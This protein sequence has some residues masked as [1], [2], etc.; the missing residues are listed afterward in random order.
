MQPRKGVIMEYN[1]P[2]LSLAPALSTIQGTMT[3]MG[4]RT[5]FAVYGTQN[6]FRPTTAAYEADE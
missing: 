5:D 3:K 6:D 1:R 4:M 2:R